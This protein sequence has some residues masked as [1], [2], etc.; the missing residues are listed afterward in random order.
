MHEGWE[1]EEGR[2]VWAV[3]GTV[4]H[5]LSPPSAAEPMEGSP[6]LSLSDGER[7]RRHCAASDGADR[8]RLD[9][10]HLRPA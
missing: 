1:M 9:R 8:D 5:G 6:A 10:K 4:A 3:G 7:G 2:R